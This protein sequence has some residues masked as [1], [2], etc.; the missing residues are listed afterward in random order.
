MPLERFTDRVVIVSGA[1]SGIGRATAARLAAEGAH[2]LACDVTADALDESVAEATK[3]A[4]GGE[5]VARLVDVSD[6]QQVTEAIEDAVG[7]WGHLHGLANIAGMLRTGRTHETDLDTWNRIL[8][9]NATGTF[10]MC[11][12]ALPHLIASRGAI[13]NAASTSTFFGHPWMAAYAASKGA[14]HSLTQTLAV[15]YCKDGVRVNAVAPGSVHS[16]ITSNVEFPTD[17]TK[18][19]SKLVR[20]IMSPTGFGNPE[21][22]AGVVAMLLSDDGRHITGE[23]IRIDGG[24]HA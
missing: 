10:L 22:V 23:T 8:T 20:R 19:E 13:V 14:I 6:E 5:V 15:E 21:D 1:A 12:A 9:V 7:R 24:T 17:L 18:D 11:R 2:V 4:A 3:G 16:G